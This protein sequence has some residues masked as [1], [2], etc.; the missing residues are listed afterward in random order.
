M[1]YVCVCQPVCV[2]ACLPPVC[3]YQPVWLLARARARV[4]A[5]TPVG[6]VDDNGAEPV[7]AT[8]PPTQ[9]SSILRARVRAWMRVFDCDVHNKYNYNYYYYY[10]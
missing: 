7:Q 10:S 8:Y 3:V 5:V 1:R 2:S 6:V 4:F 9:H